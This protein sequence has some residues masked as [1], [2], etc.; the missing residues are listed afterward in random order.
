MG[1]SLIHGNELHLISEA[2]LKAAVKV[3]V[4]KL[5]LAAGST[6][7]FDLYKVVEAYFRDLEKRSEINKILKIAE[8]PVFSEGIE[9]IQE[10]AN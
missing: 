7:G 9:E 2:E 8:D 4:D 6:E 1:K 3:I 5:D 10:E